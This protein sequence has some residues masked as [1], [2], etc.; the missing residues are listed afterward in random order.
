LLASVL[1]LGA[2]SCA[3]VPQPGTVTPSD[4]SPE[5]TWPPLTAI[6]DLGVTGTPIEVD[7]E[8]YRLVVDGLVDRPLSLSYQE[9]LAY[10][11]VARVERLNCPG[12]FVDYAEW[13]GPLVRSILQDAGVQPEATQVTFYDGSDFPYRS[14]MPLEDALRDDT[15]L[16]YL[17]YD[18]ALP[19]EHGYPLRLV[20]GSKL[21]SAW[22]K[23]LFRIEVK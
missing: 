1:L 6:E 3:Q 23:W 8:S 11:T 5:A 15:F 2:S 9:L 14:T 18:Q 20:A 12:F 21:G 19:V 10:P 22:V 16:A 7:L 17:V 13:T 4:Q